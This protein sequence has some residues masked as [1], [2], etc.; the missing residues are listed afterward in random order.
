MPRHQLLRRHLE[1]LMQ[2]DTRLSCTSKEVF[3]KRMDRFYLPVFEWVEKVVNLA[4]QK[5][6]KCVCLGLSCV[7]G[8]GKTTLSKYLE[9]MFIFTGKKCTVISIDDVYLTRKDQ[10]Q[11]A[12][13]NPTNQLLQYRG[14]PGT[15]DMNLLMDFV[16]KC[17][18]SDQNSVIPVPQY[19]KSL[20]NGRGDRVT[21]D[22]WE[23][24]Q[25]GW[26]SHHDI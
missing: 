4:K 25:G 9:K 15:H 17:K 26:S 5:G 21:I 18:T 19:D 22:K 3:D 24:K 12:T 13:Q 11:L 6:Q 23:R 1:E 14:N 20:H 7:Q 2:M 16:R 10:I 8:G